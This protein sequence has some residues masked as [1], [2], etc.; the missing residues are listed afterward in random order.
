MLSEPHVVFALSIMHDL[1]LRLLTLR[2]PTKGYMLM[3][4]TQKYLR[5]IRWVI[6]K[7]L[8]YLEKPVR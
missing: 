7:V 8:P 1:K 5:T 6:S 2:A 3:R 4:R